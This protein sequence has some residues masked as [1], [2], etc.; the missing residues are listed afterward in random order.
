MDTHADND[1]IAALLQAMLE[2]A[3]RMLND[4]EAEYRLLQAPDAEAL[5]EMAKSKLNHTKELQQVHQSWNRHLSQRGYKTDTAGI[6]AFLIQEAPALTHLWPQIQQ[7]LTI[8]RKQNEIN[9]AMVRLSQRQI[10]N[11]LDILHGVTAQQKTYGPAGEAKANR[12]ASFV[13]SV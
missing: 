7:V 1:R 3:R 4:L 6:K 12:Q 5:Q 9:G 11:T 13:C 8:A 2:G 10:A